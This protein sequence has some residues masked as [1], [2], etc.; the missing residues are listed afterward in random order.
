MVGGIDHASDPLFNVGNAVFGT[1]KVPK[2][3]A[4]WREV[5][6][7]AYQMVILGKII[8][9]PGTGPKDVEWTSRPEWKGYAESLTGVGMEMLAKA[10]AKDAK[11]FDELSAKLVDVCE[12]CH[13]AFKPDIPTMKIMH[14]P[15]SDK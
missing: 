2:T 4:E 9:L 8:Q 14:K 15:D 6:Y 11:G 12:A 13:K 1:G 7:H 3:D 10:Q 5:E